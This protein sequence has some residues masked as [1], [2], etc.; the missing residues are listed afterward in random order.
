MH[1]IGQTNPVRII[2]IAAFAKIDSRILDCISRKEN[3]SAQFKDKLHSKNK[4]SLLDWIDGKD[5]EIDTNWLERST[6]AV[7]DKRIRKNA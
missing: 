1:R 3:M 5:D 4:K 2:D 7:G 6:K